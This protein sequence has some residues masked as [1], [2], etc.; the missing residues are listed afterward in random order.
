MRI[1]TGKYFIAILFLLFCISCKLSSR[2]EEADKTP[3]RR[4]RI[5]TTPEWLLRSNVYEV[6]V[7]QYSRE[8]TFRAFETHLSR[9]KEMGVKILW[10]MPVHPIS[11]KDR[12]GTLGS[13]YAV[14][15][16]YGINPEFGNLEDFKSLVRKAHLTG[17]K[18]IID[19]VPNHTGAGHYWLESHPD[20]Y[21]RDSAGI[22]QYAFDWSDTRELDFDNRQMRDSMIAAM[23]YWIKETNID[24]FRVDV[25]SEVPLDFW[26]EAIPELRKLKPIFMLAEADK[27]EMH[28]AGFNATYPW[29]LFHTL[30]GIASGNRNA[31]ALDS[32]IKKQE[33]DFP[34]GAGRLYFT[35]NHDENSWNKS[36][37][38]TFPGEIHAPF[39]VLTHFLPGAIPLIYS[40]QEEPVLRAIEFFEKDPMEFKDFERAPFY[41]TLL[42]LRDRN[43]AMEISA[44]CRIVKV[45]DEEKTFALLRQE[46][47]YKILTIVNLS[48]SQ[49]PVKIAL[50]ELTGSPRDIFTGKQE[51]LLLNSNFVLEPWGYKVF[52]Y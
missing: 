44:T 48:P 2:T 17:F 12:K 16:Y 3:E 15:D 34:N 27:P 33:R 22:A 35:S 1:P 49:Q 41:R 5:V 50:P 6:N 26:E 10:L 43:K 18:I 14:D 29:E 32:L 28:T 31:L 39:A 7:R 37:Y 36:D 21:I 4:Q 51:K 20:F 11:E 8:G 45:G 24:G 46:G 25:A 23:Q 38:E 30:K 42:K 52:E 47:S 40:G 13:Y 9:L 19:W